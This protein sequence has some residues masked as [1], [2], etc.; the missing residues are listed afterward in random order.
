MWIVIL[1]GDIIRLSSLLMDLLTSWMPIF[2]ASKLL[3]I[4]A[5]I[6]SI[7]HSLYKTSWFYLLKTQIK[8]YRLTIPI[9]KWIRCFVEELKREHGLTSSF[10]VILSIFY[11]HSWNLLDILGNSS[12]RYKQLM[13]ICIEANEEIDMMISFLLI[14]LLSVGM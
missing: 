5:E 10:F 8:K 3:F 1:Y 6:F 11:F 7:K 4:S 2:R 12:K 9:R 13:K 14:L